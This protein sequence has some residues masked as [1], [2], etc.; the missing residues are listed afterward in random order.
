MFT[1]K[2]TS[3]ENKGWVGFMTNMRQIEINIGN[4]SLYFQFA[5]NLTH[6]RYCKLCKSIMDADGC[7]DPKCVNAKPVPQRH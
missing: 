3:C 5:L 6:W 7:T 4:F 1:I 2:I